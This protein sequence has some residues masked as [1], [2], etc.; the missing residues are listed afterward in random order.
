M[1]W[2][3]G[4]WAYQSVLLAVPSA[5]ILIALPAIFSTVGDKRQVVIGTPRPLRLFLEFGLYGVAVAGAWLV[6]PVWIGAIAT[7]IV[8]ASL[9]TGSPR[10]KWLLECSGD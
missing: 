7:L 9:I 3:T 10:A 1:A 8:I 6:W 2:V 5:V 4:P